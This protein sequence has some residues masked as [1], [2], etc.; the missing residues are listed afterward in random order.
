MDDGIGHPIPSPIS[1]CLPVWPTASRPPHPLHPPPS[2]FVSLSSSLTDNISAHQIY[3]VVIPQVASSSFRNRIRSSSFHLRQSRFCLRT[4]PPLPQQ[5]SIAAHRD[6]A[7]TATTF[8]SALATKPPPPIA[9]NNL[10]ESQPHQISVFPPTTVSLLPP[11][12]ATAIATVFHR[13]PS[14][15]CNHCY[16]LRLCLSDH[17]AASHCRQPPLRV[18]HRLSPLATGH[19][20]D[21]MFVYRHGQL[22]GEI[23]V[24]A[25][26]SF[27]SSLLSCKSSDIIL[28]YDANALAI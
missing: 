14:R 17:P 21:S 28:L 18:S 26:F 27:R 3:A 5:S 16:N 19:F 22:F 25:A 15:Q 9:A 10:R 4:P 7:A 20:L 12:V 23:I 13:R 6:S 1:L 2:F 11:H 24:V 8:T